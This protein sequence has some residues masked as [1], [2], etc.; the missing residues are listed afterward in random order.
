MSRAR[1]AIVLLA[2]TAVTLPLIPLQWLALRGKGN[3]KRRLPVVWHRIA[4]R[5][6]GIK[7]HEVG[8]PAAERPLLIT[9]NHA[10]WIDI[11][12]LGSRTPLSFIAKTEVA[13]WPVFG[14]FAKL[15]RSVFVDRQRRSATARTAE[16]IGTR[17]ASGDAMVL[18]AEGT[19]NSGNYVLPFR[20]ALIGAA[21][22]AVAGEEGEVWIQ[23][24]AIAY[25]GLH[26]LPM[27]RQFRPHVAWY[28]DMEMVPHFMEVVKQGA[29]DVWVVWGEP[30]K[31]PADA[32]RKAL[33]RQLEETVRALSA[34]ALAGRAAAS[35]LFSNR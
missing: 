26:G 9:A 20:S 11:T 24:L 30:V 23:P 10:S 1:A 3:L 7:V 12:V 21:R 18:F 27:G 19:S 34:E 14:L 16:E 25:T 4:C 13:N 28:G 2:L 29:I 33:T 32:D 6:V 17:M 15:Q 35:A 5:M 31:V 22:H 8:R